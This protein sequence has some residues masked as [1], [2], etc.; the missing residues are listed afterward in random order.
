MV[1]G[2]LAGIAMAGR[3]DVLPCR[4]A[5]MR[6]RPGRVKGHLERGATMRRVA[7]V[8]FLGLLVLA[9]AV[10]LG[11]QPEQL[12]LHGA[13]AAL[14]SGPDTDGDGIVDTQDNCWVVANADQADTDHDCPAPPYASDPRC[15]D[16]CEPAPTPTDEDIAA[17]VDN[18]NAGRFLVSSDLERTVTG[19]AEFTDGVIIAESP[20]LWR[21]IGKAAI[22]AG[23][24]I[25]GGLIAPGVGAAVG[26]HVGIAIVELCNA[27][28]LYSPPVADVGLFRVINV[29]TL[30]D[31]APTAASMV[32]DNVT[33]SFVLDQWNNKVPGTFYTISFARIFSGRVVDSEGLERPGASAIPF[34]LSEEISGQRV[35][36]VAYFNTLG[37]VTLSDRFDVD[38]G[39]LIP[40][41]LNAP[42]VL[43]GTGFG[44][45]P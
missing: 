12:P 13:T 16:A 3:G 1:W 7:L 37:N 5:S 31:I 40:E 9:L 43:P 39:S 21:W 32:L 14:A 23:T 29:P 6:E 30:G 2:A 22:V 8:S 44:C 27:E 45:V 20:S 36:G 19:S 33:S 17:F 42:R 34:V 24:T 41:S 4:R 26:A 11:T 38:F 25:G 15:G 28:P 35:F 18:L 10:A